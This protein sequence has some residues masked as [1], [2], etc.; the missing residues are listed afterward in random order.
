MPLAPCALAGLVPAVETDSVSAALVSP[1]VRDD[2]LFSVPLPA[3]PAARTANRGEQALCVLAGLRRKIEAVTL[4]AWPPL[5]G[6][7]LT[8]AVPVVAAAVL[9]WLRRLSPAAPGWPRL[10]HQEE[11][12]IRPSSD[13]VA[14]ALPRT[15]RMQDQARSR[16]CT[17]EPGIPAGRRSR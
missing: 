10:S 7:I 9:T 13:A 1:R 5:A 4:S 3:R 15:L 14:G 12:K 16:G 17:E 11:T 2:F 8:T 6:K